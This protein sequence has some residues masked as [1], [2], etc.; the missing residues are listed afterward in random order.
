MNVNLRGLGKGLQTV[1]QVATS[2]AGRQV[3][4]SQKNSP[5]ILFGAGVVGMVGTVVLASRATLRVDDILDA[6]D[7]KKETMRRLYEDP[8]QHHDPK[9]QYTTAAYR[10]DMTLLHTRTALGIV[11]LYAPAVCLGALSIAALTG[12]H[13]VLSQRNAGLM[14]AYAAVDKGFKEYRERVVAD[15]GQ[16]KDREYL[17]GGETVTE[18]VVT[19]KGKTKKVSH[20]RIPKDAKSAY[21]FYFDSSNQNWEKNA[22]HNAIFLRFTQN[23]LNDR[24]HAKGHLFLNE[25]LDALGLPHT[26]AGAVTGWLARGEGDGYVDFQ[27]WNN[28]DMDRL[29]DFEDGFDDAILIEFNVDGPIYKDI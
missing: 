14:A 5:K 3:L 7:D 20:V 17:Y 28:K 27:C 16:D 2:K 8:H 22:G 19:D 15:L 23:Q 4:L 13:I 9:F 12:S 1:K 25:A 29:A 18:E 6:H 10:S 21:T 11:K 26:T 24:L